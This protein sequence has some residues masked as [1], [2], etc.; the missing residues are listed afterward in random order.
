MFRLTIY[1]LLTIGLLFSSCLSKEKKS[2][3][4]P[5]NVSLKDAT[6][7]N[8]YNLPY[9]FNVNNS[10]AYAIS[11]STLK[12]IKAKKMSMISYGG[13]NPNDIRE[14]LSFNFNKSGL[15]QNF[16][17]H[18]APKIDNFFTFVNYEYQND[19]VKKLNYDYYMGK[20][21]AVYTNV[22][23]TE[24]GM[25]IHINRNSSSNTLQIFQKDGLPST[26]VD[27]VGDRVFSI[28]YFVSVGT[29]LNA[30]IIRQN[31]RIAASEEEIAKCLKHVIY[32]ENGLP[33]VGYVLGQNNV[34]ESRIQQ[35]DYDEGN[36]IVN[37]KQWI[38]NDLVTELKFTYT[39]EYLPET[40]S[41]NNQIYQIEFD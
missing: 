4:I 23:Y 40:I 21:Q 33:R 22:E 16:A 29:S 14:K 17:Y 10:F 41:Y 38:A 24:H 20:K 28:T 9:L 13:K 34:Q 2:L 39:N 3:R 27:R 18:R 7:F 31:E 32:V 5:Q 26:V 8:P 12:L 19:R 25:T 30:E 1:C 35:Y 15:I 37:Y 6:F 36:R 11:D